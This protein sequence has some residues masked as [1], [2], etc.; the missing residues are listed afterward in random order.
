MGA[1]FGHMLRIVGEGDR[2]SLIYDS[3]TP[4]RIIFLLTAYSSNHIETI[5]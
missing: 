2:L 5:F 1:F 3:P 4:K